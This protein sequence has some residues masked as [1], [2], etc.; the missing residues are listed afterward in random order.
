MTHSIESKAN[1]PPAPMDVDHG[2]PLYLASDAA[3]I[4][5]LDRYPADLIE[6]TN[7]D[8]QEEIFAARQRREIDGAAILNVLKIG[9]IG[10]VLHDIQ[11]AHPGL[12]AEI[13]LALARLAPRIGA[14]DPGDMTGRLTISAERSPTPYTFRPA[15]QVLFHLRGVQRVWIY[16]TNETYLPQ[17][18]VEQVVMNRAGA[19]ALY[20]V[21]NYDRAS[22]RFDIIAGQGL[23]WPL[24]SPHRI[25]NQKGLCVTLALDYQ[26]TDSRI[27]VAAHKANSVLR[28]WRLPVLAM[29][30]TPR[31]VRAFLSFLAAVF[32]RF[33][34]LEPPVKA[35]KLSEPTQLPP[36]ARGRRNAYERND[37]QVQVGVAL[38][39]H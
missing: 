3:L 21:P 17:K 25:E 18:A 29:A 13:M 36:P 26:T 28:R 11:R 23:A 34:I 33:D 39:A 20:Y 7:C 10:I 14:E 31:P 1:G 6:V 38:P 35:A 16:P 15:G 2:V 4:H 22:W 12:W 8:F 24:F 32:A 5:I 19:D 30:K 37:G 27:I 9:E